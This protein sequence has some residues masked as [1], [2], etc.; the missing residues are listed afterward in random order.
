MAASLSLSEKERLHSAVSGYTARSFKGS[1]VCVGEGIIAVCHVASLA[2][3]V[4]PLL[5]KKI[6]NVQLKTEVISSLSSRATSAVGRCKRTIHLLCY[7]NI[8][9]L[10]RSNNSLQLPWD[11]QNDVKTKLC[12]KTWTVTWHPPLGISLK[13]SIVLCFVQPSLFG[14]SVKTAH[15]IFGV[16]VIP[17]KCSL[18]QQQDLT[19]CLCS[20]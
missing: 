2:W 15:S 5:L 19:G 20:L 14:C 12:Q 10:W 7:Q 13:G 16:N 8:A 3:A 11:S 4:E 1:S 6:T 17:G 18:P 9:Y